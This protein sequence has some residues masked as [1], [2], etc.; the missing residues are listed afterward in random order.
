MTREEVREAAVESNASSMLLELPTGF[1]K[2]KLSLDIMSKR[3][4]PKDKILIVYFRNV[5]KNE[6]I[7]EIKKWHLVEYLESITFSTYASFPKYKGTYDMVI[8]DECHHFTPRCQVAAMFLGMKNVL[9]LSATVKNDLRELLKYMFRGIFCI[10]VE[11]KEAIDEGVL[12]DPRVFLLPLYLEPFEKKYIYTYNPGKSENPIKV[13][14]SKRINYRYQRLQTVE[15]LCSEMEYY[16]CLN[17]QISDFKKRRQVNIVKNY[18]GQRLKWLSDIKE[19]TVIEVL[20]VLANY[21]TLTFCNSIEQTERLGRHCINS[22]NV[23]NIETILG[24]FNVGQIN[25]ITACNMLNEGMNLVNCQVGVYSV[26]NSS[27]IMQKQK[28]GRILRHKDPVIIIPYYVNTREEEIVR[29]MCKNYN[30]ELITVVANP[31]DIII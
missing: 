8:F 9:F 29:D 5:Q 11:P 16:I 1:G 20:E 4:T 15:V 30:P 24:N 10:K 22:R 28:L 7:K 13:D 26:L 14:F 2:T 25:H 23:K 19:K 6:W 18:Q 31:K 12:P 17:E 21:R 27:E 3:V